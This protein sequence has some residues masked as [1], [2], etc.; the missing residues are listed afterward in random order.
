MVSIF[1]FFCVL[2]FCLLPI[3]NA[4]ADYST[5]AW[6]QK[7]SNS[8]AVSNYV[9]VNPGNTL[10]IFAQNYSSSNAQ[11]Q[12]YVY[13]SVNNLPIM[14][15]KVKPNST[16]AFSRDVPVGSYKI[17]IVCERLKGCTGKGQLND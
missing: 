1:S 2:T 9:Y 8:S 5:V 10:H 14:Q 16:V 12:Y 11:M 6:L 15:G 3:S 7:G 17:K 13:N 4:H